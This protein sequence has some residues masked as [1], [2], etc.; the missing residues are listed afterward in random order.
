MPTGDL[1][2]PSQRAEVVEL[3]M[4][5]LSVSGVDAVTV[6]EIVE[7]LPWGPARGR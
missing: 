1:V 5:R 7:R 3:V 2:A 6:R 4:D